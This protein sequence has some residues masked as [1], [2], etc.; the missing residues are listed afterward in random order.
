M[1]WQQWRSAGWTGQ[2]G[3]P[4]YPRA[5]RMA[6]SAAELVFVGREF[7]QS[8]RATGVE[9]VGAHGPLS[10]MPQKTLHGKDGDL[11]P[12]RPGSPFAPAGMGGRFTGAS[13]GLQ[14]CSRAMFLAPAVRD[15][16]RARS[17][18]SPSP[19]STKILN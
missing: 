1:G 2:A 16:S 15:A 12:E 7:F 17:R 14:I 11:P 19:D 5:A 3:C 8:H 13:A 6:A 18:K 4:G 9:S 10:F